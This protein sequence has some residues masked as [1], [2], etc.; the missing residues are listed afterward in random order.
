MDA[1]AGAVLLVVAAAGVVLRALLAI[2]APTP[3]GYVWDFYI[4]GTRQL[5]QTGHLPVS[6]ACWQCYHPPLFYL[7]GW[8]F[9]ALGRAM[10]PGPDDSLALRFVWVLPLVSS[11]VTVYFGYRLLRLFRC[12]GV[13]L[14]AGTA[15]LV[16]FPCLFI[17][18]LGPDADILLTAILSAYVYYLVRDF[19]TRPR[20]SPAAAI[21]LGVLAG[22]AAATKY[23]GL[24]GVAVAMPVIGMQGLRGR[25]WRLAV[26]DAVIVAGLAVAIGG[27]KYADNVVRY[28]TPLYAN[29]SAAD[30]FSFSRR[31][32]LAADYDFTSLRIDDVV[33]LTR[34]WS[35]PGEL[36][37]LPVYDSVLTTLHALAWTDMSFFSNPTRHGDASKPYPPKHIPPWLTRA[38]LVGGLAPE[39]LALLGFVVLLRHRIGWALAVFGL[40]GLASYTWWFLAEPS[41]GLKTKYILF[42]LP[43]FVLYVMVALGWLRRR[44]P[45]L[46]GAAAVLVTAVILLSG[47]YLYAFAV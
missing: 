45:F 1:H 43:Q 33:A 31:L 20:V 23:S 13:A 21:R 38:M 42:L 32:D 14:V 19:S 39:A 24:I 25:H 2:E 12:R 22:L 11:G 30:G 44:A 5:A 7:L 35:P 26:R 10:A 28:G 18:S 36:A 9:Y 40:V 15:L 27:W 41:W 3:Y 6:T 17:G 29:G 46:F 47:M 16:T 37:S 8:P 4:D 34:R